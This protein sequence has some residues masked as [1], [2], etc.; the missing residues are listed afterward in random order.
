VD[1]TLPLRAAREAV[2]VARDTRIAD[3][4]VGHGSSSGCCP[5]RQVARA[6]APDPF[7]RR[8]ARLS[9]GNPWRS[10][11]Y[12]ARAKFSE[13]EAPTLLRERLEIRLDENLN[14]LLINLDTNRRVAKVN[15][16]AA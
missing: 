4:Q 6:R 5:S 16:V 2:R 7:A 13:G 14:G 9:I 12:G 3:L 11:G 8:R 15:L 10:D 1:D